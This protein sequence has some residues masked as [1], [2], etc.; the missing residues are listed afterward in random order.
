MGDG[1]QI[2]HWSRSG[3]GQD[4]A[5]VLD[6]SAPSRSKSFSAAQVGF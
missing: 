4:V 6:R 5:N 2:V 3:T 1:G